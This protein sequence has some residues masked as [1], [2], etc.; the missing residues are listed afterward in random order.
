MAK[1]FVQDGS[2]LTLTAPAGGVQSGVPVV[3][4]ALMVVPLVDAEEGEQFQGSP[5]GVWSLPAANGLAQ[6]VKCSLLDGGLVAAG[7]ASS[8]PFGKI[9]E[10]TASG[11]ASALLIQQ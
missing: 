2:V 7:T 6:G 9:T 10:A 4:G 8:V 11:Y 5:G 3:V 1:N